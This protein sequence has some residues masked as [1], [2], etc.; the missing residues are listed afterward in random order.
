[1]AR[2]GISEFHVFQ[3][4]DRLKAQN[5]NP[6]V[7]NVRRELGD[8]GSR[9]TINNHLRQW[10]ERNELRGRSADDL[11]S[12]L[13]QI[14]GEQSKSIL[15]ALEAE[16]EEKFQ[17]QR[18]Q[19]ERQLQ[20]QNDELETLKL[21]LAEKDRCIAELQTALE[22]RQH[23]LHSVQSAV[24]SAQ[25]DNQTLREN[26]ASLQ[27][28]V[29]HLHKLLQET[30]DKEQQTLK[31][32]E[33]ERDAQIKQRANEQRKHDTEIESLR[34][35]LET[36]KRTQIIQSARLR[37][38]EKQI[39]SMQAEI[40]A[41]SIES[42]RMRNEAHEAI[43]QADEAKRLAESENQTLYMRLN[44]REQENSELKRE[45]L[46][47]RRQDQTRIAELAAAV[48]VLGNKIAASG[49]NHSAQKAPAKRVKK[50]TAQI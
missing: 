48:T 36:E 46:E 11:S 28:T 1:M 23:E 2:A 8:T 38:L 43:Q 18:E 31:A 13:Q 32:L 42:L 44:Q 24:T 25:D 10:R 5:I 37:D 30:K 22:E 40:K 47:L 27:A 39:P 12:S 49:S 9:T 50:V 33:Q 45:I 7:D 14:L 4:A 3:A 26:R 34:T 29:T 15:L 41:A 35:A 19:Y 20:T 16:A 21:K 17:P 6:T